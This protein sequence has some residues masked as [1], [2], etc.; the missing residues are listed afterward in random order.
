MRKSERAD[1]ARHE[2]TRR[3][4]RFDAAQITVRPHAGWV[5][6]IREALGMSQDALARR[7]GVTSVAVSKFEHAE[8]TGGITLAK[9][10]DIADALDCTLV[11]ALVP[12]A[13]LDETI[14]REARRRAAGQLGYVAGTM[15]LED[16]SVSDE[17]WRD[18]VERAARELVAHGDVWQAT[19]P[20]S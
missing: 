18:A 17:Q 5:R 4:E 6:A 2:L 20:R 14:M 10:S 8:K 3:F 16:Q 9:L 19:T 1:Q 13:S 11:Y 12:R 15:A 7:L